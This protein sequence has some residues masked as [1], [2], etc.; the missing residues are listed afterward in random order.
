MQQGMMTFVRWRV[1]FHVIFRDSNVGPVSK[2]QNA[3]RHV[4]VKCR[5]SIFWWC[6]VKDE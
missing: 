2:D 1:P 5:S 3:R 6:H 4:T